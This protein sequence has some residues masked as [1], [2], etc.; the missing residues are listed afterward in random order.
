[1]LQ[2]DVTDEEKFQYVAV[3]EEKLRKMTRYRRES[4]LRGVHADLIRLYVRYRRKG[5][6]VKMHRLLFFR[7]RFQTSPKF[8]IDKTPIFIHPRKRNPNPALFNLLPRHLLLCIVLVQFSK[9]TPTSFCEKNCCI[10]TPWSWKIIYQKP[11]ISQILSQGF[12]GVELL[13]LCISLYSGA[14]PILNFTSF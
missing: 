3:V 1:M 11:A 10:A 9:P 4:V 13:A 6:N 12:L 5:K 14:Q 2:A 7:N 8:F